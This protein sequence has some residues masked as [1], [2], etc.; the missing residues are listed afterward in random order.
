[1]FPEQNM[2]IKESGGLLSAASSLSLLQGTGVFVQ[3]VWHLDLSVVGE[4]ILCVDL[5]TERT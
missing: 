5:K 2:G 3:V 1:M 4:L